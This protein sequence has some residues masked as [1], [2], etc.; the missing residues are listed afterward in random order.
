MGSKARDSRQAILDRLRSREV[1]PVELPAIFG[2]DSISQVAIGFDDPPTQFAGTVEAVGGL[3]L[4]VGS[5]QEALNKLE[6]DEVYRD[7]ARRCSLV[8]DEIPG[9]VNLQEI[10]DPHDLSSLDF[11]IAR[12]EF[13]VAENGA[14]W[15]TDRDIRHRASLFITQH[16]ALVVSRHSIISNMHQAYERIGQPETPFGVFIAGPSKTADIE[17]SLVLGAHGCRTL[18]VFLVDEPA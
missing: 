3:C 12:A 6:Q 10:E 2:D 11:L 14:M 1:T 16:L 5:M 8:G 9:N 17:Q 18:T 4:Q 15:I 7:A 13:G